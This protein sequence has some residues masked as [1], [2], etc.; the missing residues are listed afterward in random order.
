MTRTHRHYTR[1]IPRE[2]LG[3]VR[4][5]EF[6]DVHGA[7]DLPTLA[8]PAECVVPPEPD[9][10]PGIAE[11]EHQALVRQAH[12]DGHARGLAEGREQARLEWQQRMDDYVSGEGRAAAARLAQVAHAM[13]DSLAGMQQ[14]M[15]GELL[16]LACDVARQVVRQELA[17]KP[18]ALLPVVRE[19]LAMLVG[20]GRPAT[21]RLSPADWAALEQ[22]LRE[23]HASG[24]IAWQ[25]DAAVEPGD[26]VVESAGMVVDGTLD[27]R[28]RRAIAALGLTGGWREEGDAD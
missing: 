28:W 17:A 6:G 16:Q 19:A 3:D 9:V 5:W 18:R 15:A 20:E 14:S 26:C 10:P 27:K 21:V 23:E 4:T 13:E 25:A 1:F 24:R 22:P 2:E 8:A 12:D 7:G 11:A